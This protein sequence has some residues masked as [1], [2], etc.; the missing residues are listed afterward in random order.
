MVKVFLKDQKYSNS[1]QVLLI[2]V[3]T[4]VVALTVG[5]S[6]ASRTITNLKIS[7][8]NEESTRAFQAAEAG[9][10]KA[11]KSASTT[12]LT[13]DLSNSSSFQTNITSAQGTAFIL[14]GQEA[15]DQDSGFDVWLSD[16]PSFTNQIGT[17][18]NPATIT[19]YWN[20]QDQISCSKGAGDVA[21]SS[22]EV[23]LLSGTDL[24]NPSLSKKIYEPTGVGCAR[25]EGSSS[26]LGSAVLDG[27]QFGNTAQIQVSDGLVLKVV[28]LFNST[29]IGIS[30]NIS[31]PKQGSTIDSSGISGDTVRKVVYFQSYPQVPLELFPYTLISQ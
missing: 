29:K 22:L 19:L 9:I 12:T 11:L 14:N 2:V 6:I 24:T 25:I 18:A 28:P 27:V 17:T 31:L 10:E 4:M 21:K 1:G 7:K 3:L 16:Y 5:L 26:A 23:L 13:A 8:Q 30:S 15:I 20:T